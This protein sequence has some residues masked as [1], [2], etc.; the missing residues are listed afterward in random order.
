MRMDLNTI[1][2]ALVA[3][4][5]ASVVSCTGGSSISSTGSPSLSGSGSLTISKVFPSVSGPGWTPITL[6]GRYYVKGTS[7]TVTGVCARGIGQI[8]ANE[9]G[10]DYSEQATCDANGLFSWSKSDYAGQSNKTLTFTAYD[11]NNALIA[12]AT[13]TVD[14]RMDDVAP[15]VAVVTD[16]A[17]SPYQ[18]TGSG[19]TYDIVGTC[20]ADVAYIS[21][22][23][24]V[25]ITPSGVN[26]TYQVDLTQGSTL[27]FHFYATDLAGNVAAVT[28]QQIAFNPA[29]SLAAVSY[30]GGGV[31]T[32]TGSFL[33]E[34]TLDWDAG[35]QLS[36][37]PIAP[38]QFTLDTGFNYITNKGRATVGYTG[39]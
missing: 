30:H 14:V 3:G 29:V 16:P 33:L 32:G 7:L 27:D 2:L 38:N 10:P 19:S 28:L 12:G 25:N 34:S 5:A 17:A 20:D 39:Y 4:C 18:Y 21:T 24:G 6:A 11:V 35:T 31:V 9:G 13:A 36:T 1:K 22:D 8:H 37:T 15:G 23:G 26:W